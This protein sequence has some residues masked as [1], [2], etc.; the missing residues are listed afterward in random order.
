[1][2]SNWKERIS[3]I[4]T[5]N[6]ADTTQLEHLGHI[7]LPIPERD[8]LKHWPN[9]LSALGRVNA[10]N[11]SINVANDNLFGGG[12]NSW[13]RLTF[14]KYAPI[15]NFVQAAH[16][17]Y[18]S[19]LADHGWPGLILFLLISLLA[20]RTNTWVIRNTKDNDELKWAADLAKML[21][22]CL[23]AYASGGAFL[24]LSYL[25]LYWHLLALMVICKM[26]TQHHL[27]ENS[28]ESIQTN[29]IH[30]IPH[31]S[32][33]KNSYLSNNKTSV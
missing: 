16:S 31:L 33:V 14:E 28:Q 7:D 12:Y 18:F 6:S 19:V 11:Y 29:S 8:W 15:V 2:P 23:M 24:S 13:D 21:Q 32:K 20:W 4:F 25:D 22:V 1:M 30:V 3:T 26:L 5:Q 27:K 9:D 10:W 17:I